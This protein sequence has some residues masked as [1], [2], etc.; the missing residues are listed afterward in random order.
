MET[1]TASRPASTEY[2][3]YFSNYIDLVPDGAIVETLRDQL[4]ET[5]ALLA[6][7]PATAEE[8]RYEEGKWSVK[9]VLGHLCDA[10]RI[11]S[12]R[13]LRFGRGDGTPLA[14]FDSGSYV[15]A[16]GFGSRTL[17]SI[18][19][20]FRAVREATIR[21][22]EGMDGAALLRTGEASGTGVSVRALAWII[23]G[24][25]RHHVAILRERYG[26]LA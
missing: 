26:L 2:P 18:A 17:R 23:A 5:S 21:L 11:F 22:F 25:E 13:A 12:Y 4:R 1:T 10:E 3:P 24:H 8:H 14:G 20:E 16:G 19:D 7:V 15:P 6:R 9:E